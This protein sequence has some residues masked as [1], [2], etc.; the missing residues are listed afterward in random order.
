[1]QVVEGFGYASCE[2]FGC[3][4]VERTM[5]FK[6][7]PNFATETWFHEQVQ[8]LVV[9]IRAIKS[10]GKKVYMKLSTWKPIIHTLQ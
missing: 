5:G 6:E 1:M 2:K 4:F 7:G 8:V 9:V 3:R 10:V